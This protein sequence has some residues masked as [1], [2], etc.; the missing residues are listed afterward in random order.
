MIQ[1]TENRSY[2]GQKAPLRAPNAVCVSVAGRGEESSAVVTSDDGDPARPGSL[3]SA[4][5]G[6]GTES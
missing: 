6:D 5:T 2:F 1:V 3:M 4:E